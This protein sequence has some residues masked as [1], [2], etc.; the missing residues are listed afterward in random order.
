MA[1][2]GIVIVTYNSAAEIGPCLDSAIATGAEVVVVD[3]ASH[4]ATASEVRSRGVKLIA[5]AENRGFA[6]AVNQGFR[7]LTSP[8]I[9]LLNP[10]AV[11][12]T[13]LEPMREACDRPHTA[14]AGGK[15]VNV[16]GYP[17]VGF[18]VRR[19]PGP[20]ALILETLLLNRIWPDNPVNRRY[21]ALD[22]DVDSSTSVEQPAGAFLM[23][24]RAVWEELDGF[25]EGFHPLWFEDV[26][27]SRRCAA[28]GY[29][30]YYVPTVV[31]KHTGAHSIPQLSL[32][33]R[34][35]YWYRSLLRFSGKHFRPIAFRSVCL[36]VVTG[37]AV[38]GFLEA[39]R[40]RSLQP[41]AAC[42][43]VVRLAGRCLFSGWR[44]GPVVSVPTK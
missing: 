41:M 15:L 7:A 17:Q 29:L 26:D 42:G 11:I 28:K 19:F 44:D 9:L 13:G 36:A 6:A 25:D 31:A 23:V 16:T 40:D 35:F 33:M 37:S 8:Y 12:Q 39:A 1:E 43:R 20:A 27:F 3:N 14:A 4:D 21:R 34:R 18:M 38:R 5:N 22:L 2:I 10:D 24:R 32:E 30:S